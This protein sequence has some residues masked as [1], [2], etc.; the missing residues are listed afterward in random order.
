MR[1]INVSSNILVFADKTSNI[2]EHRKILKENITK[3]Y[4]KAPNN[5]EHEINLEAKEIAEKRE[6]DHRINC[7]AKTQ[8]FIT[9]KD[10]K[11]DFRT[12]P[13]C[14]LINPTKSEP[15]KIS[16]NILEEINTKLRSTLGLNQWKST[17]SVTE[18]FSNIKSKKNS[19]FIQ[20]DIKDFYPSITEKILDNAIKLTKEYTTISDDNIRIIKHCRK[21]LLF[22]KDIAWVKKGTAGNFD[23]TMGSYDRAEVCELVEIYILTALGQR[24]GLYR[25]DGFIILRNCDGSTTDRRRKD[26]IRIFKQIGL[27][28]EIKTN[29]K[30]VDFLDVT[31]DFRKEICHHTKKKMT[32]CS[33]STHLQIIPGPSLSKFHH[34]S[35]TDY[36]IIPQM[37]KFSTMPKQNMKMCSKLLD[38]QQISNLTPT[39]QKSEI[40]KGT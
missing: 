7:L 18:W 30:E 16:K 37:K 4:K 24:I 38:T 6:L 39:G 36:L 3:T 10:H 26:I 9:M 32:N 28:I 27:K 33:T 1:K 12:N 34:P 25:D 5:L 13:T 11:E 17:K 31:F 22:E 14:R 29:L 23:V 40:E 19:A 35:A 21:S 15:G 20:L 8:A 2:Y